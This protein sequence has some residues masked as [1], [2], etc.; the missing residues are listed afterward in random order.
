MPSKPIQM[1]LARQLASSLA[2]PIF[3][4]DAEG[5]VIYFNEG[6]EILLNERFEETGEI[7]ADEYAKLVEVTD[8]TRRPIPP[9]KWPTRVART[10]RQPVS[11]TIWTRNRNS[12]WRHLQ[13]T[14]IPIVGEGGALHGVMNIFWEL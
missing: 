6:A 9:E 11:R 7:P 13:V 10:Q 12:E 3:L 5:T 8:E 4:M 2:T 1:I 14:V